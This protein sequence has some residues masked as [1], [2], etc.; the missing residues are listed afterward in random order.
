MS[1]LGTSVG[2]ESSATLKTTHTA[3]ID[4][5]YDSDDSGGYSSDDGSED[6]RGP[7]IRLGTMTKY[8]SMFHMPDCSLVS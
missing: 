5:G 1:A 2:M 6:G 7:P 3:D 4:N 8:H